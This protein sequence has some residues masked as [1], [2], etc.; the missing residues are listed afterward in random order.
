MEFLLRLLF[1]QI[2]IKMSTGLY[3]LVAGIKDILVY[4]KEKKRNGHTPVAVQHLKM[5]CEFK[6]RFCMLE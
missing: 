6:V 3:A 4:T 2:D 5:E 1:N